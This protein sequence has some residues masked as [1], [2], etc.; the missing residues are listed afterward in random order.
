MPDR[1]TRAL[2]NKTSSLNVLS[3]FPHVPLCL[4]PTRQRGL[5][6]V[7]DHQLFAH[8]HCNCCSVHSHKSRA[9][10]GNS[11]EQITSLT[12]KQATVAPE[13]EWKAKPDGPCAASEASSLGMAV[14]QRILE[15]KFPRRLRGAQKTTTTT[16]R[17]L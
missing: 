6:V 13:K 10:C 4:P 7:F 15:K 14:A 12:E 17:N 11:I 2:L 1:S 8:A 3:Y 16:R 9:A 5:A